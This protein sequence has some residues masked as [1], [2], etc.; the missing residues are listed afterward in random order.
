MPV[1]GS[2]SGSGSGKEIPSSV[3]VSS[4]ATTYT[5]P[6]GYYAIVK[7]QVR[8]GGLFFINGTPV[9]AS[10]TWS[11]I[12]NS[13]NLYRNPGTPFIRN[14]GGTPLTIYYANATLL[15]SSIVQQGVTAYTNYTGATPDGSGGAGLDS[16]NTTIS[17]GTTIPLTSVY[18][19]AVAMT[20]VQQQFKVP[21]GT[22]VIG[23][24][25]A[26]YSIEL[27]TV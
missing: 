26:S 4:T 13:G 24:G 22:V 7:A 27:Y 10:N 17:A 18:G 8:N 25:D 14:R 2:I 16:T 15:N 5:I 20:A 21:T 11:T 12:T 3:V 19:N 23:S 1:I 9:L 6:A